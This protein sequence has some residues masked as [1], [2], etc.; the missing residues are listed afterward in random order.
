[1]LNPVLGRQL[2]QTQPL[3]SGATYSGWPV[4]ALGKAG[5]TS[6]PGEPPGKCSRSQ[7]EKDSFQLAGIWVQRHVEAGGQRK[8]CKSRKQ[9]REERAE[10]A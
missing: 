9:H 5:S 3:H 7:R 8:R 4:M 10:L 1:M 6:D 2:T